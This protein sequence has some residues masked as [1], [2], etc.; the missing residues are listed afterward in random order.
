[1]ED[2][3]EGV[4]PRDT[5]GQQKETAQPA[6]ALAGKVLHVVKALATHQHPA[7]GDHEHFVQEVITS[8][9]HPRIGQFGEGF[10]E[11][12][13]GGLGWFGLHGSPSIYALY[14]QSTHYSLASSLMRQP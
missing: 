1:L 3:V 6:L 8:P 12:F 14:L 9:D 11:C 4:V 10:E 2:A 7:H 5:A 13:S